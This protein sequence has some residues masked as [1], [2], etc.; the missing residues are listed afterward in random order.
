MAVPNRLTALRKS[1]GLTTPQLAVMIG[2]DPTTVYRWE[3]SRVGIP[4]QRKTQLAA[5]FGVC[6][7]HLMCWPCDECGVEDVAA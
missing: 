1:A 7:S 5:M 3:R 2:V 4:D 6:V